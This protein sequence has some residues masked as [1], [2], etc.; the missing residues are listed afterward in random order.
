MILAIKFLVVVENV[1][2]HDIPAELMVNYINFDVAISS[3]SVMAI[4][5][6]RADNTVKIRLVMRSKSRR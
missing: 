5:R 1:V 3:L 6:I 2:R 4:H